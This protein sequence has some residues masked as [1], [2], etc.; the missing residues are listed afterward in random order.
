MERA[1]GW[2]EGQGEGG[3]EGGG[4]RDADGAGKRGASDEREIERE[5]ERCIAQ[6][7]ILMP[8]WL[9]GPSTAC[10]GGREERERSWKRHP[11]LH[12]VEL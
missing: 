4:A 1:K 6:C 8:T 7:I 3:G 11:M 5:R 12:S 2:G 10:K 9:H